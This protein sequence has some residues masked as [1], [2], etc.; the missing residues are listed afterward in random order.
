M[1]HLNKKLYD[2]NVFKIL[3]QFFSDI[4]NSVITIKAAKEK[5]DEMVSKIGDLTEY[6]VRNQEK[7][8]QKQKVLKHV[9]QIFETRN[10]IMDAFQNGVFPAPKNA[11][12]KQTEEEKKIKN[13]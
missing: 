1:V 13:S 11:Q 10:K 9:K 2:F 4:Y 6:N 12:E 8:E 5:Q 3:G 7:V